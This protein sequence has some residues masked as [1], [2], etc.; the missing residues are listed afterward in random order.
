[1]NKLL[2]GLIFG[3]EISL[4]VLDTTEM[5]NKAIE[6]HGLSPVCAAA[7]GRTLTVCTFMASNLKNQNDKLS[8]TVAGNG[9]GGKITVCGNGN[10][11]MRGF[12]DNPNVELPL[13]AD[14]KLNV[15]GLVGNKGRLT[16][17]RSMGLKDPYSGSSELV[18]GEIAEDFTAYYA[19]SE[20]QPTAIALG[21]KIG[22][23]LK[24]IGAGGVIM[25]A[26]PGASDAAI[27]MAEDVMSQLSSVS[28]LVQEVGAE[29]II[30]KFIGEVDY[31]EYHPDYRCLCD[32]NYIEKVLV[33]LGKKELDDI[34]EKEGQITV[35]CQFCNKKYNFTNE[36]VERFFK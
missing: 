18:S 29:G 25:Q 12:I 16:V 32:R 21:V 6:I 23:D 10:L 20:Q 13:R 28:T 33:S 11:D 19:L 30:D 4:S 26:M 36:D 7:L 31:T 9:P 5:V 35:D 14:G 2:K 17:V 1:M 24:C 27:C 3:G 15:G 22:K 8:V 34:I